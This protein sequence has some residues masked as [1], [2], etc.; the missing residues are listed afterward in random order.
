MKSV[1]IYN[2]TTGQLLI[3]LVHRKNGTYDLEYAPSMQ[4]QIYVEVRGDK[5]HKVM[6]NERKR[7]NRI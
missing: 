1:R 5:G 3:K 2:A 7:G 6:F 4:G